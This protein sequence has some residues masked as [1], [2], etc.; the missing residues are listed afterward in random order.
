MLASVLLIRGAELPGL[1]GPLQAL[2]GVIACYTRADWL[3]VIAAPGSTA[4]IRRLPLLK[5]H[6]VECVAPTLEDALL[7]WSTRGVQGC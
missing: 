3:R 6:G 7:E 2:P 5:D 4:L 1:I